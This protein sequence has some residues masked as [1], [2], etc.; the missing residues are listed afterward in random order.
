MDRASQHAAYPA[1]STVARSSTSRRPN[2]DAAATGSA[3][4]RATVGSNN[5]AV[6]RARTNSARSRHCLG[7]PNRAAEH[8]IAKLNT[9]SGATN[10]T[11]APIA[12]LIEIPA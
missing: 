12:P 1:V 10:A 4:H 2:G 8:T 3:N 6:P 5:D 7:S 11:V 9:R